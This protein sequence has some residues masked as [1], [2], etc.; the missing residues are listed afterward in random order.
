M[1]DIR[2][3]TFNASLN[4]SFEGEL[5]QNLSTPNNQQAKNVAETIQRTNP[6]ILL[7]NEFDYFTA[8][9]LEPVNLFRQ[10]YLSVSQN[11]AAPVDYPYAYI[12]PS[13]TGIAS[14]FDLN[15]NGAA[16]TTPG[17]PGYGDDAFGFGNFPGQFGMVVYS[18][19]P[20]DTANVR[21]FQLFKWKDM[22]GNLLTSDPTVDN[23]AT[24]INENLNGF[25]SPEEIAVLRL[26]SKSHW[27]VPIL[28]P[29]GKIDVLVSHPTPPVFDGTEDR[30]GK[31]NFDEIRFWKDYITPGQ[32]SYIRDDQGRSGGLAAG[33]SFV[34]M[35]DLNSDPL[36]GDSLPNATT[37][38]LNNPR[39]NNSVIPSSPG[40]TQQ[41]LE[42]GTI[43]NANISHRSDPKFDT[44]DFND[45][46]PGNLRADYVLPSTD[47]T[48]KDASVFWPLTSDPLYRLVGDRQSFATTASSDHSL[49]TVQVSTPSPS[50]NVPSGAGN[51]RLGNNA[52]DTING[53]TANDTIYGYAGNDILNSDAGNDYIDGGIG[54][55]SLFGG[56]GND[57][58]L[59]GAGNDTLV[60]AN[61]AAFTNPGIGEVDFL[62]GGAGSDTFVLASTSS[63]YYSDGNTATAGT[64]DYAVIQI[65]NTAEDVIRLKSGLTYLIGS[66]PIASQIGAA[67]FIDQPTDELVAVLPG[68]NPGVLNLASP[69]FSFA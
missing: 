7:I 13:N 64:G 67:I 24:V 59:G 4:R 5:S 2:F 1:A 57:T 14:G 44:A 11:G 43:G 15:N 17:T 46:A 52:S 68:V 20:I 22:P 61:A 50:T 66:S 58:L 16:V 69:A 12:A 37:Q 40:G 47:L 54:N 30:N 6:D 53:A 62:N 25:Y 19:Y 18:K 49:V 3:A 39:I 33:A 9:P 63:L 28:T 23:P 21:S 10:N 60:G 34:I 31:R 56:A 45:N 41:G 8:N 35:G 42:P 36:D 55:D 29:G 27:D 26:S 51:L 38:L 48:I 32:A 65:F